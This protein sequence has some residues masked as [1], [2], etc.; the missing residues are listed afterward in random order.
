MKNE[1]VKVNTINYEEAFHEV[2]AQ[3]LKAHKEI[4]ELRLVVKSLAYMLN[5]D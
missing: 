4:R 3:L 5:E 1:K 2:Q